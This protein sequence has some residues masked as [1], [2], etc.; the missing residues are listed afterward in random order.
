MC[1]DLWEVEKKEEPTTNRATL[2]W[3]SSKVG[4]SIIR[5]RN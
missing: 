5:R 1:P 2:N 3:F 4:G